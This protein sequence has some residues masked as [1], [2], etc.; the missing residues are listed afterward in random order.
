MHKFEI[1]KNENQNGLSARKTNYEVKANGFEAAATIYEYNELV[2]VHEHRCKEGGHLLW[3]FSFWD[4]LQ[5]SVVEYH[6]KLKEEN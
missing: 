6:N 1:K 4:D 5:K 3:G 2:F